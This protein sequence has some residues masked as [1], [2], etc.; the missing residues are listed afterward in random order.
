[1]LSPMHLEIPKSFSL[2]SNPHEKISG[3]LSAVSMAL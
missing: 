2:L 1:M 3:R